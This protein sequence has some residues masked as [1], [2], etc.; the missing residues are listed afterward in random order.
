MFN[1]KSWACLLTAL[2][3]IQ[4]AAVR[5]QYSPEHP[6]VK[7]MVDRGV[8]YLVSGE[9]TPGVH[10]TQ[11]GIR[12]IAG[13]AVYKA[14][15][16]AGLAVVQDGVAAALEVVRSLPGYRERGE[17]KIVYEASVAAIL[18]ASVDAS[19]YR[20]QL[21]TVL[22]WFA[23]VQKPHGGFGYLGKPT[24]DTSQVQYVVLALWT[25]QQVG[26]EVPVQMVEDTINYL[27][28][29]VD[30]SGGWGYQGV[31]GN[32]R[33]VKQEGVTKSLS[34]AGIG[35]LIIG[36]DLLGFYGKRQMGNL[37]TEGI[38]AAFVRVDLI[39]K[40]RKERREVSLS[41]GDIE[42][43]VTAARRYQATVPHSGPWFFYW[44]YSQERYES[45][46]EIVENKQNKSPDWYNSGVEDMLRMQG[47]DGSWGS[48]GGAM[49]FT[50]S[51]T[52]TAFAILFLIRST[53][54]AIGQLDEGVTFGGY[55]LPDDVSTIKMVG[56]RIVSDSETS[57][58]NLLEMLEGEAAAGVEVGLLPKDLQL[59]ADAKQRKEQV[60]RLSRLLVSRDASARRVA[61][62]LLGRS[63][64]LDQAPELIFA[65]SD[66]D[67]YVPMIAEESL[68]LL[69]RKLTAG[70]L[71]SEPTPE[72]RDAAE[73][74]WKNWYLG[75]RP[76]YIFIDR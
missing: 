46:W 30:P 68:R 48:A 6:K 64:D 56:E 41:K 35:A 51:R 50:S 16:D 21:D 28:S 34:T 39:E 38:P 73:T 70:K 25:M 4:S 5:A 45:F 1:R 44:R 23:Q 12:L 71:G 53:Q 19:K 74:Y 60:A 20:P 75:L 61:A 29:T 18:L 63:D 67:P 27:R 8:A 26:M 66:P 58:Q 10:D 52:E 17:S 40:I 55:R 59:A 42:G 22:N 37:P 9:V 24:G 31:L 76:D 15:G 3:C 32:G 72:Q 69:S 62:K 54:K 36:A 47:E 14:T 65:L 13:Y 11:V 43:V 33:V 7:A 57:V 2:F 49:Q